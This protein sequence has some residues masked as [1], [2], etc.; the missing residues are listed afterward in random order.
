[1]HERQRVKAG[2]FGPLADNLVTGD[3]IRRTAAM[4]LPPQIDG[5]PIDATQVATPAAAP[6]CAATWR[7][8]RVFVPGHTLGNGIFPGRPWQLF[9]RRLLNPKSAVM[10]SHTIRT[11][12]AT[13]GEAV[14]AHASLP[15]HA[16]SAFPRLLRLL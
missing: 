11:D 7:H 9:Q 1:M 8:S 3:Y 10:W 15:R 6:K 16:R 4:P 12:A 14:N 13:A 5:L 2:P